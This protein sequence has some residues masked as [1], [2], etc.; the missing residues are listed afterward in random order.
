MEQ[1]EE[2]TYDPSETSIGQDSET[3][4]ATVPKFVTR[5]SVG[6]LWFVCPV[7]GIAYPKSKTILVQGARY[8]T[9]DGNEKMLSLR[10]QRSK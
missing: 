8:C 4:T 9:R 3:L 5:P 6:E 2:I 10:K 1:Y 7:C